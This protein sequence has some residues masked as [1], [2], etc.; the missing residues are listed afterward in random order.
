MVSVQLSQ[1]GGVIQYITIQTLKSKFRAELGKS[2]EL[3]FLTLR[4]E[5]E[6]AV[7]LTSTAFFHTGTLT[8]EAAVAIDNNALVILMFNNAQLSIS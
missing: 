2:E 1:L 6:N 3:N 5:L 7:E 8:G 4:V